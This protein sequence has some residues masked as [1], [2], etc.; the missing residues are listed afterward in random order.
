MIKN[1]M[2]IISVALSI[3]ILSIPGRGDLSELGDRIKR[4]ACER[5]CERTYQSCMKGTGEAMNREGQGEI[6][7][8]V[9]DVTREETC[10]YAK[11]QCLQECP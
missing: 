11:E 8:D 10:Q 9:K 6:E 7:S 1:L 2:I 3:V 4:A 5:A